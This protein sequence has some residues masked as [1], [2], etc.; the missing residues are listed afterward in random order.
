MATYTVTRTADCP[1]WVTLPDTWEDTPSRLAHSLGERLAVDAWSYGSGVT[2]IGNHAMASV[3]ATLEPVTTPTTTE[4]TV[5]RNG[6]TVKF[7]HHAGIVGEDLPDIEQVGMFTHHVHTER[8]YP[9][10]DF[11]IDGVHVQASTLGLARQAKRVWAE[12]GSEILAQREMTEWVCPQG[13]YR[14]SG[15]TDFV[16]FMKEAHAQKHAADESKRALEAY[17]DAWRELQ[18]AKQAW[19]EFPAAM[20]TTDAY[21]QPTP[22]EE[23]KPFMKRILRANAHVNVTRAAWQR[24]AKA[25]ATPTGDGEPEER[26]AYERAAEQADLDR[27][28]DERATR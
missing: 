5:E 17:N 13:D 24:A 26:G 18:D 4:F 27:A 3:W 11:L 25:A 10:K 20:V 6:Q 23:A 19:R 14:A 9:R 16:A 2:A 12:W 8:I 15:T 22:T 7:L 28:A 21:G 1:E